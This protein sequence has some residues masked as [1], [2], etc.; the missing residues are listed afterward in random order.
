MFLKSMELLSKIVQYVPKSG[1]WIATRDLNFRIKSFKDFEIHLHVGKERPFIIA[2]ITLVR[3]WGLLI[4]CIWACG[5]LT[6]IVSQE[7]ISNQTEMRVSAISAL[8][9]RWSLA[10]TVPIDH[11]PS[12]IA[13][14]NYCT[15]AYVDTCTIKETQRKNL[16]CS[17]ATNHVSPP[18]TYH[19]RRHST[20]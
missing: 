10:T 16:C 5:F 17:L 4:W 9:S 13:S 11:P 12:Q 3:V 18:P 1:A 19:H 20:A 8:R 14:E 15:I 6:D 2:Q 7:Q